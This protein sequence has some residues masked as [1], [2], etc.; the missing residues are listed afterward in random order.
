M[1]MCMW[2]RPVAVVRERAAK[3][4]SL[5]RTTKDPSGAVRRG[6]CPITIRRGLMRKKR[7][8]RWKARHK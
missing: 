4:L 2:K 7:G 3:L 6:S 1:S 5:E 8:K